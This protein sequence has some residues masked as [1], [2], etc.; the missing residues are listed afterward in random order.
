MLPP[1]D[2]NA[3]PQLADADEERRRDSLRRL[4]ATGEL[5]PSRRRLA[6]AELREIKESL[7]A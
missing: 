3:A 7:A 5:S 4:I 6:Q 1:L 2:P